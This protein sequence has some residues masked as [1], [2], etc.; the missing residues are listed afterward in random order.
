MSADFSGTPISPMEEPEKKNN[1][2][3]I[4]IIVVVVIL[5]CCCCAAAG[6]LWQFGD[7]ILENLGSY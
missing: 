4:I 3:L 2:T 5:L 6:I 1:T 7:V